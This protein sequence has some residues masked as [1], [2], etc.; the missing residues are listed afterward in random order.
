MKEVRKLYLFTLFRSL[1]FF[2]PI[3]VAFY[4]DNLLTFSQIMI[5]Q[6]IYAIATA[7]LEIPSGMLSDCL[8][9]K[10]TLILGTCTFFAAY[11]CGFIG[12]N[13][14][15]FAVMQIFAAIGQSC[16]SGTFVALMYENVTR[17][18]SINKSVNVIFANMQAI[19]IC[20]VLAASFLC[21][22]IVKL[23]SMRITYLFTAAA[24]AVTLL[25]CILFKDYSTTEKF[26]DSLKNMQVLLRMQPNTLRRMKCYF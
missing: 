15:A 14:T 11:M 3:S 23:A 24:Y 13:W 19:N 9:R 25:V 12:T 7:V 22:L 20:A 17:D 4:R 1:S 16:Y 6:S 2:A 10:K 8:G 21:S 26:S 18:K 5:L